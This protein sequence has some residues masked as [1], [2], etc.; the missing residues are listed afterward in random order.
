MSHL[1]DL[2]QE[3]DVTK[4]RAYLSQIN[5]VVNNISDLINKIDVSEISSTINKA[6][7]TLINTITD[8]KGLLNQAQQI[9]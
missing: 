1:N 8:A 2:M 7:T 3:G 5:D 9:D 4:I 6:L